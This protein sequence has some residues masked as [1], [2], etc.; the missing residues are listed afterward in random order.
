[1]ISKITTISSKLPNRVNLQKKSNLTLQNLHG[2]SMSG[3][4]GPVYSVDMIIPEG[5]TFK[6]KAY[7]L[8]TGELSK[9]VKERWVEFSDK[10][11][12][13]KGDQI[14]KVNDG[15]IIEAPH[16][17]G[18]N[19]KDT[20]LPLIKEDVTQIM[21]NA[22]CAHMDVDSGNSDNSSDLSTINI[23]EIL[24]GITKY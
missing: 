21:D 10:Y 2:S 5:L 16:D 19:V 6:E 9:S 17:V 18:T 14:V 4:N 3:G 1:M 23:W 13:R 7:Y 20:D 8:L 22:G 12:P 24:S 15:G 11:A